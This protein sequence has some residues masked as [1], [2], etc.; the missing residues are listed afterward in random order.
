[1]YIYY[2][3][4]FII[5]L[6]A[7]FCKN[8]S[9]GRKAAGWFST[10]I[11]LCIVAFRAD[12]VGADT[13]TY[14]DLYDIQYEWPFEQGYNYIVNIGH[15]QGWD[16]HTFLIFCS[17]FS[18]GTLGFFCYKYSSNYL[19]S[20][21]FFV[22][23]GNFSM[24]MTGLR[25]VIAITILIWATICI[26]NKKYYLFFPLVFIAS[27][28][29]TSAIIFFPVYFVRYIR[30][31]KKTALIT[32]AAILFILIAFSQQILLFSSVYFPENYENIEINATGKSLNYLVVLIEICITLFIII[33]SDEYQQ[34]FNMPHKKDANNHIIW[35]VFVA[36]QILNTGLQIIGANTMQIVRL[37]YYFASAKI[38]LLPAILSQ[39]RKQDFR[40]ITTVMIILLCIIKFAISTPGGYSKIDEY[41]FFFN[42]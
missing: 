2:I 36:F 33:F 27:T 41:D 39:I 1:M 10:F 38:V 42:D 28:I 18:I 5:L 20:L 31:S 6:F 24:Y 30:L 34:D 7:T 40:D 19:L 15:L 4:I 21:F 22:T 14:K 3:L 37:G 12:S 32:F 23:I 25:Q 29:H 11:L 26:M 16:F 8:N 13:S 17:I 35:N 9:N